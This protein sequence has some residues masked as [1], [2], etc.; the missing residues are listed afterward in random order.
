M[1]KVVK[2]DTESRAI[3]TSYSL[4]QII[5]IGATLGLVYWCLTASIEKYV[6]SP[7]FCRSVSDATACLNSTAISGDIATI[8][9]AAIGIVITLRLYMARP[10]IIALASGAALWGLAQW[11]IGLT[12]SEAIAWSIF[13]YGVVYT[14]FSWLARY[15]RTVPILIIIAFIIAATRIALII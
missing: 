11:T 13:L 8:I 3:G 6:I 15:T 12:W 14:L 2:I 4:W 5:F 9:V 10:L 7:M 1:A